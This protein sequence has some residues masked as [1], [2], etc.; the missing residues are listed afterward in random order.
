M[1]CLR[2][3]ER[4][5]TISTFPDNIIIA[6]RFSV[7]NMLQQRRNLSDKKVEEKPESSSEDMKDKVYKLAE[8]DFKNLYKKT[9]STVKDVSQD[10]VTIGKDLKEVSQPLVNDGVKNFKHD[11]K[12]RMKRIKEKSQNKEPAFFLKEGILLL[13]IGFGIGYLYGRR[14]AKKAATK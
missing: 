3:A 1:I 6:R 8:T 14:R 9:K 12:E 2:K 5:E 4:T 7:S 10:L 13:A 11:M